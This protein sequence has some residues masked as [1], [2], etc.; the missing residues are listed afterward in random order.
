MMV[1]VVEVSPRDGLQNESEILPTSSKIELIRRCVDA[2]ARRVEAV[3]FV[4]PD[5]VPQMADAE[6]VMAGVPRRSDVSYIGLVL[7]RRG[8][9]RALATGVDEVNCVVV[10]TETFSRRN[11]GTSV[12]A[13]VRA[14]SDIAEAAHTA[15]LRASVTV[16]AAFGCPFEGDVAPAAIGDLVR[17]LAASGPDEIALADTIGVGVP[18]QVR[19]LVAAAITAAPGVPL[20]AHFHDTRNTGIANALAAVEAGVTVL[21]ASV[22]GIGG[23]PFAPA[24]TGNVATEDLLYALDRSGHSTG[25]DPRGVTETAAWIGAQL[26]KTSLPGALGRAGWFPGPPPQS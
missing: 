26:G 12:D 5:R 19:E 16:A 20:R 14:W 17:R 2:G 8:L 11:Q 21:D 22:G 9:D 18:V 24:A 10:A 23:C 6:A 25:L 13:M 7:N 3:S 15:G 4:R 1:N